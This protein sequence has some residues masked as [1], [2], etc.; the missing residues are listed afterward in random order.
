MSPEDK[1]WCQ[2]RYRENPEKFRAEVQKAADNLVA[3]G[4]LY[5][6]DV[7]DGEPVYKPVPGVDINGNPINRSVH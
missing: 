4:V 1:K 6:A 5:I 2:Q 7:I 3:R